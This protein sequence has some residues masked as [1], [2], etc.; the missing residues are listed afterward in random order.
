MLL[1]GAEIL[2]EMMDKIRRIAEECDLVHGFQL[3]HSISGG[4]G[5][6]FG[7]LLID[8]IRQE[9][10]DRMIKSYSIFPSLSMSQVVVNG[11]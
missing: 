11:D 5:G 8:H 4:A 1:L 10:S 6:G 2:P 3:V 7:S 9:Y